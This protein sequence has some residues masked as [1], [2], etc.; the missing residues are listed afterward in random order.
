MLSALLYYLALPFI[1]LISVLPFYILYLISD[2]FY[3]LIF[4]II[5]YR[6][7]VV[8]DNLERS[9]PEKTNEEIKQIAKGFYK[10]FCDLFVEI[11]KTLTISKS[12]II[13]HCYLSNEATCLFSKL[14]DEHKSIILVMGHFG[15]WEWSNTSFAILS[16]YQV[17][18][19]YHTLKHKQFDG[20]MYHMRTRFGTRM[21]CKKD[22]FREMLCKKNELS[23][24]AFIADQTPAPENAYWTNFLNQDTPVFKGTELIARKINYPVIYCSVKRVKRGYYKM[25]AEML[26][27]NPAT[28]AEGYISEAHTRKLEADIIAQPETWLWSHKRWKHKRAVTE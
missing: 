13:K 6:K 11:L 25:D 18:G 5:G 26:A 17:Y 9:F 3:F 2:G 20:L 22:T 8:F 15:N 7:K 28:T 4:Y 21:I 24:T 27:S 23:A 10:Y 16:R 1:Y 19:I 14:A 12:K